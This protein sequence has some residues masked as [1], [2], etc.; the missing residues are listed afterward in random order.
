M[1]GKGLGKT[2]LYFVILIVVLLGLATAATFLL[3]WYYQ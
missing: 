1:Q 2:I 3:Q